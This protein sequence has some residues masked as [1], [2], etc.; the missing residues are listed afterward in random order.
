MKQASNNPAAGKAI[1]GEDRHDLLCVDVLGTRFVISWGHAVTA[2]QWQRMATA[3]ERCAGAGVPMIPPAPMEPTETLPF[4]ASVAYLSQAYDGGTLALQAASFE[5]LAENLTSRLTLAAILENAGR[6][7]MLHA[8]GVASP[9]SGGVMALVAKSGTGKTTAASVLARTYGY[10]S[11]ETVAIG[12]EGEVVPYPKPLSVKQGPGA[13]KKQLG[14]GE[15][16]LLPA[17]PKMFIQSIVLLDRVDRPGRSGMQDRPVAPVLRQLPLAD[18]LLALVPELSSQ[19]E[20][21]EPLQS[22]CRLIESVGGIWQV[23]YSEAA[24]L[25]QALEPLFRSDGPVK[26][27]WEAPGLN[28][29]PGAIPDGWVRRVTPRDA[30]KVDDDLLVMLDSEIVRLGGVGP[31]IWE[32]AAGAM[33]LEQLAEE[34]GRVH[35]RDEGYRTAVA[36]AVGQLVEKSILE[37]GGA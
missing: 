14:P 24:D 20:M 34:V 16:G 27:A 36:A 19:S 35:G 37:Q 15:L 11:D 3:W 33:S 4:S 1:S 31:A 32:A 13:P 23:T 28:G 5:A 2:E 17:L 29:A 10:V 30:V 9:E 25:P 18:G 22:L 12:P 21:D 26:A 7:I 8:C 6:L